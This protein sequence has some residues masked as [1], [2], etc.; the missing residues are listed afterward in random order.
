[1]PVELLDWACKAFTKPL[2]DLPDMKAIKKRV[3]A[4]L[5]TIALKVF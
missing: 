2:T 3:L 1:V 5:N 4:G